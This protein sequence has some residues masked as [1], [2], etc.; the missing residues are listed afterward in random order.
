LKRRQEWE[1]SIALCKELAAE[2]G[3]E[4]IEALEDL[5]KHLEHRERNVAGALAYC[6]EAMSRLEEDFRLPLA[7]RERWREAFRRRVQRLKRREGKERGVDSA[8]AH[9]R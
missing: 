6:Q 4:A 2:E 3:P 5:A 1:G 9:R 8:A 7:F